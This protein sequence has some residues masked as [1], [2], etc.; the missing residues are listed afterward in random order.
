MYLIFFTSDSPIITTMTTVTA[1]EYD[2]NVRLTCTAHSKPVSVFKWYK[3]GNNS[4]LM[5]GSGTNSY[6]GLDIVIPTPTRTYAGQFICQADNGIETGD[7]KNVQLVL[8]C[9]PFPTSNKMSCCLLVSY[10]IHCIIKVPTVSNEKIMTLITKG[11]P[12][13]IHINLFICLHN[14][15]FPL[16]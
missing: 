9:K 5:T 10:N 11:L 2:T 1:T 13:A 14:E 8:N 12:H 15:L 3:V 7:S 16:I 4:V 6:N